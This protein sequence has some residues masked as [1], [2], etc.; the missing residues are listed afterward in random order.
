MNSRIAEAFRLGEGPLIVPCVVAGDPSFAESLQISRE[1]VNA[2]A[3]MLEI[4]M[5]FSD[6]VADGPVIQQA[7]SRARAAGMTT[8][9]LFDLVRKVRAETGIPLLIMTYA[10][11]VV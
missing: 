8:D 6:P 11:I 10:N 5:P 9:R 2:G 7:G 1:L 4:V 3:D